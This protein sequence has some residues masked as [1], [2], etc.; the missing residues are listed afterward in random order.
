MKFKNKPRRNICIM[1]KLIMDIFYGEGIIP[2]NNYFCINISSW[3]MMEGSSKF[4]T[5]MNLPR[6]MIL[7]KESKNIFFGE[8][9]IRTTININL[10]ILCDFGG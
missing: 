5:I 6:N 10:I 2:S 1:I 9:I 3:W 8:S 4:N 7:N